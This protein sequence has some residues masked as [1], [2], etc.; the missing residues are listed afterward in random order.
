MTFAKWQTIMMSVKGQYMFVKVTIPIER[1]R[2]LNLFG[3]RRR[4]R[5]KGVVPME[6]IKGNRQRPADARERL[7]N[8]ESYC[9]CEAAFISDNFLSFSREI[10]PENL[11]FEKVGQAS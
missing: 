11:F 9:L 4:L 6:A 7:I 3:N 8:I 2:S 5:R 1:V 10:K